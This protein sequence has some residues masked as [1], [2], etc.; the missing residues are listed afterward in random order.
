MLLPAATSSTASGASQLQ[1]NAISADGR[2]VVF[3]SFASDLVPEG[4]TPYGNLFLRD[5]RSGT[6][7]LISASPD[8]VHPFTTASMFLSMSR[9]GRFIAFNGESL[10]N[11]I[12]SRSTYVYDAITGSNG[13]Q[14]ILPNGSSAPIVDGSVSADGNYLA[15]QVSDP[16]AP[17]IYVRDIP[18]QKTLRLTN[19]GNFGPGQFQGF[20]RTG[21]YILVYANFQ[22]A[23]LFDWKVEK[24]SLCRPLERSRD[25]SQRRM[26]RC[27]STFRRRARQTCTSTPSQTTRALSLPQMFSMPR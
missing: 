13:V 22:T 8:A 3:S 25:S 27:L 18:A 14:S 4:N 16:V 15:F 5:L 6:T 2:F 19:Y 12:S 9:D 1:G 26:M 23:I 21:Q 20:S 24:P 11:S 7:R 17:G 10:S